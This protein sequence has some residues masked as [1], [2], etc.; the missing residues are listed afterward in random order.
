MTPEVVTMLIQI[1]K[2]TT[3]V[4]LACLCLIASIAK[5]SD[6][7]RFR[8]I[9]QDYQILP[10]MTIGLAVWCLPLFEALIGIGVLVPATSAFAAFLICGLFA[11][12][13]FAMLST[14]Y[15]GKAL[16]DCGCGG[17]AQADGRAQVLGAWHII[18]NLLLVVMALWIA[19]SHASVLQ[20]VDMRTWLL[21]IPASVFALI[22]Y[23]V[24]DNLAANHDVMVAA[25]SRHA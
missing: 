13:G 19:T 7:P 9:V 23:W 6:L 20:S 15:R 16:Q 11:L 24:A 12:Y 14:I 22:L 10:S 8:D 2:A 4:L 1:A 21:I 25:K 5:F 3:I 17:P 18:R